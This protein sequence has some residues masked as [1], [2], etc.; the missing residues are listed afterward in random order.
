VLAAATHKDSVLDALW[1][2]TVEGPHC[3]D[4]C[5]QMWS[6]AS[7]HRAGSV[8]HP[9]DGRPLSKKIVLSLEHMR[10]IRLG[11]FVRSDVL[12][13]FRPAAIASPHVR[14]NE[15]CRQGMFGLMKDTL[16]MPRMSTAAID[17]VADKSR[18]DPFPLSSSGSHGRRVC[19]SHRISMMRLMR[20]AASVIFMKAASPIGAL[21]HEHKRWVDT[22]GPRRSSCPACRRARTSA[23]LARR[24]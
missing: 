1:P 16:N 24:A 14:R 17:F 6:S 22:V 8:I 7:A 11:S 21:G 12:L 19:R 18:A 2:D 20:H 23:R 10:I 4:R 13:T 5:A 15:S 3:N 9:G